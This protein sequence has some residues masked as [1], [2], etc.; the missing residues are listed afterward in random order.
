MFN[1]LSQLHFLTRKLSECNKYFFLF[2]KCEICFFLFFFLLKHV[3]FFKGILPWILGESPN[4]ADHL[5]HTGKYLDKETGEYM[6]KGM[7][8]KVPWGIFIPYAD[9][10]YRFASLGNDPTVGK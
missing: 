5:R 3:I 4:A 9:Q 10:Y 1:E 7:Y 6:E 8:L 2:F